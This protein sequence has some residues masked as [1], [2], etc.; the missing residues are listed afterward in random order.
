V[1]IDITFRWLYGLGEVNNIHAH[2]NEMFQSSCLFGNL[3]FAGR[4]YG[5]GG[6]DVHE[7]ND[8]AF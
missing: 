3:A 7:E 8:Y 1:E 6:I 5:L 4:L 2:N